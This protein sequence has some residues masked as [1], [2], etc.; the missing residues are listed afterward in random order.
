MALQR[1]QGGTTG[2]TPEEIGK[3]SIKTYTITFHT[4]TGAATTAQFDA[5]VDAWGNPIWLVLQSSTS[6]GNLPQLTPILISAGSNQVQG[7]PHFD[8]TVDWRT[9]SLT[10][11]PNDLYSK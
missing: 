6:S 8:S 9:G 4:A 2:F 3:A 5:I 7:H 10:Q 1:S 11:S